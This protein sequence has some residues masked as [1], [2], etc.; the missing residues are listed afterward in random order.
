MDR[1]TDRRDA[2]HALMA[3]LLNDDLIS[4][5]A[6]GLAC[7]LYCSERGHHFESGVCVTCGQE[8]SATKDL[9]EERKEA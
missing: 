1:V 5:S 6:Y 8:R 4:Y 3:Q 2:F 7:A 9:S